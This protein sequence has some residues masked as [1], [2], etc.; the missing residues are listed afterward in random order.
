M[1]TRKDGTMRGPEQLSLTRRNFLAAALGATATGISV[2]E[3]A[4]AD[5]GKQPRAAV[6]SEQGHAKTY[7]LVFEKG[8]EFMSGLL[9]FTKRHRLVG[10][11]FTAIGAV[12]DAVL[13]FFDR[14]KKDYRRIPLT[15][16]AEVVS[17]TGN[18][19]LRE[20]D[21]PA[22]PHRLGSAGRLDSWRA[23]FRGAR[24]AHAGNG[25]DRVA[26]TGAA[27][28]RHGETGLYLLDP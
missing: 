9:E 2:A 16:Q 12:S 25:A 1:D 22:R 20:G 10:G 15:E 17:L 26:R 7:L 27:E 28:R 5:T 14:K 3:P 11:Q 4:V 13:G 23:P 18:V 21:V 24:L 6:V 8:D 19:A